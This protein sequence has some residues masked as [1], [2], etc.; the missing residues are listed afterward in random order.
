MSGDHRSQRLQ[1]PPV[2][3]VAG[4]YELTQAL[5]RGG[6]GEVFIALDRST[7][8]RV[9]L[10]RL[11]GQ[12]LSQRG[13]VVHFMREYHALSELRHPR[14]IEVYD[15]GVHEDVPYYTMELLDGQ[16]LRDLSPAPYREACMY[17]RDVA[18]SLALL[19]ARR[20]L[21][22]DVSPRNVRRTSEGHCKLIDFGAMIA[23]GVPPNV[24]GTAPCIPPEALQGAA[25]DQRSDLYALGALAYNVLTGRHGHAVARLD[26]LPAAWKQPLVRPKHLVRE[27][28]DALDELVMSLM[29]LDI[30]KRPKSA[31]EVIDWLSAIGQLPAQ[32]DGIALARSFLISSRLCGRDQERRDLTRQLTRAREGRGCAVVIEGSMGAGKSRLL[33]EAALIGQTLGLGVVRA[34]ARRQRG[35]GQ[36]L[37]EDLFAALQQMAPLEVEQ[38]DPKRVVWPQASSKARAESDR[39]EARSRLQ[40]ALLD[41]FCTVAK[42]RPLLV[43]VDDFDHA[44]ELSAA[45]IAALAHQTH[46]LPLMLV[47]SQSEP[48]ATGLD[49]TA[50]RLLLRVLDREQT[51]QLVESMFGNVPN[52]PRMCEWLFRA[53]RGNPKLTVE[54]AEHL[55]NRG[56]VRY[57]EGSW[58]LPTEEITEPAPSDILEALSLRLRRSSSEAIALAELLS[59][60][61]GGANAELCLAA[62]KVTAAVVFAALDELVSG[63]VLESAGDEYAFAQDDV[64]KAL[65]HSLP[66]ERSQALHRSWAQA[67]QA[68]RHGDEDLDLQL[69][70]GWHLVHTD[71]EME[72]A[73][74]LARVGPQLLDQGVAM[75]VA[76]TAVEKA[77]A[78]YEK[79]GRPLAARLRLRSA[80]VLA[81]YLFDFRLALRYGEETIT[82]L[83]EVS[84]VKLVARLSRLLGPTLGFVCALTAMSVLRVFQPR[85][86]RG[87]PVFTAL[88]YFVRSVM[89]L[90]GV[91]TTGLDPKGT[92]E[93]LELIA[94]LERAPAFTS[95]QV[96]YLSCKALHLELLGREGEL[97]QALRA[98]LRMLR[99]GRKSDMSEMEYQSLLVGLLT[100]DG[101][102]EAYRENSQTLQRAD[103]L[104]EIG[105]HLARAAAQRLRMLYYI[106]R[107]ATEQAEHY[108]RQIELFAIQGGTTWQVEWFAVANEG[109]AGAAWTDLVMH[110]RAL[111]RMDVFV[112]E[113][114]TL[115]PTRDSLRLSYHWRRGEYELAVTLGERY[116]AAHPPRSCVGWGPGYAALAQSLVESGN[117]QRAREVCEYALKHVTDAD[118]AYFAMYGALEAAYAMA[119]AKLG[120]RER[121]SEIMQARIERL[122]Q[123][124]EHVNL[125]MMYQYQARIA[126]MVDDRK[127]LMQALQAMRNA[128]LAS[129][130]PAVIVLA[131]RV[132]ELR[133][134]LRSSP[135]PPAK[136]KPPEEVSTSE[137]SMEETVASAFLRNVSSVTERTRHAL[138]I[139]A[140]WVASD[141]AYLIANVEGVTRV[142]AT[143]DDREVPPQL[144]AEV[145]SL[146]EGLDATGRVIELE[147]LQRGTTKRYRVLLLPSVGKDDPWVGAAVLHEPDENTDE[148]PL[149]LVTD[150]GRV[151]SEDLRSEPAPRPRP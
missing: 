145:G 84:G 73:D 24:T 69:E 150:I 136:G 47:V 22:R 34:V 115:T 36:P 104:D 112:Q 130:F 134:K 48:S 87:P 76:S 79:H 5:A 56:L 138:R 26:D 143:L 53:A 113:M 19:H 100:V 107:G 149:G 124:G 41:V 44:D 25:L 7:G 116:I 45:L 10:K 126:R 98:A 95:G 108:R 78:L 62:S 123:S 17:L 55:L 35:A 66:P 147:D 6:M 82:V 65:Q 93:L 32:D 70:I 91:R 54:L 114:P 141:E 135:L 90:M 15:Y 103:L 57:V 128:A 111:D 122:R 67:L 92:A 31:A 2:E 20:L 11:H 28:P 46:E 59:V 8:R 52:I 72:G 4:R 125:V 129:G 77:L 80:L 109:M 132:A 27:I 148:L 120:E 43:T 102:N 29:S 13:V 49:R 51:T 139:L 71:A 127:G 86:R 119:L 131:D 12:A 23:F 38:A 117:P 106:R 137:S 83:H 50:A 39:G 88:Q 18:S 1:A 142:I 151:L 33:S 85:A 61:R 58:V 3:V 89:G 140:Q 14:I 37:A 97:D 75:A 118:R 30:M 105:T 21:H 40:Q 74:L 68:R 60:R 144:V 146:L 63:G 94:P 16:D 133:A 101:V 42:A 64:R 121:S 96:V 110:R 99:R 9:A 81:G